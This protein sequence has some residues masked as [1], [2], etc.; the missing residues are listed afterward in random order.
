MSND[1]R[2]GSSSALKPEDRQKLEDFKKNLIKQSSTEKAD[3]HTKFRPGGNG[4]SPVKKL[5]TDFKN[6]TEPN[7]GYSVTVKDVP[8]PTDKGIT[9]EVVPS[10]ELQE[11]LDVKKHKRNDV[12]CIVGF[13]PSWNE[14]PFERTDVD[15]WGL[16]ELYVY[17]RTINPEP[18]FNL[19]FEVH[20]IEKSPSKQK[21]YHQKFLK[22]MKIPL[23]T[24]RH[25]DKY[26]TSQRYPVDYILKLIDSGFIIE[27]DSTSFHDYS[28][29]ISW[30]I[31]LAM[32]MEY[33]EIYVYGVDMAQSSEY[34][35]QKSSCNFF[36]GACW[37]RGIKLKIPASCE[38]CTGSVLY[39]FESDNSGRHR[40]KKKIEAQNESIVRIDQRQA[41][42]EF[43][44][45]KA[46]REFKEHEFRATH[47]IAIIEQEIIAAET[48][49]AI[50]K[51]LLECVS[52]M[53]NDMY[54]INKKK[55]NLIQSYQTRMDNCV[56]VIKQRKKE[57]EQIKAKFLRQQRDRYVGVHLLDQEKEA[58]EK[59][60]TKLTGH[61]DENRHL[62]SNN[63]V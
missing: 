47:D 40:V 18:Q 20:N 14:A 30:M 26:P 15:F 35:F 43:F 31:A 51:A 54:S 1:I 45:D 25:W 6:R 4:I 49:K 8:L 37:G 62:L 32:A 33:K 57:I 52:T 22:E 44:K 46:E 24:Q 13:A 29:Q 17:L 55:P 59:H 58:N 28:N 12:C 21:D 61:V 63:L 9:Q 16:N 3:E 48:D 39:G 23:I 50:A 38:L 19:W 42:I 5:V 34:R 10:P 60:I 53:P 11:F 27:P 56:E 7:R 2:I 36:L 41:E